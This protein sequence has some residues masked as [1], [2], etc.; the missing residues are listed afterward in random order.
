MLRPLFDAYDFTQVWSEVASTH[1]GKPAVEGTAKPTADV[2]GGLPAK[3]AAPALKL[4]AA[5]M[6]PL[7]ALEGASGTSGTEALLS[8]LSP[9]ATTQL[10]SQCARVPDCT[11]SSTLVDHAAFGVPH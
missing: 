11:P 10:I 9:E 4:P 7:P 2:V 1:A 3:F 8:A 5:Y 6:P